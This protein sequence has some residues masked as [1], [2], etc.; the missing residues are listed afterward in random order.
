MIES[1]PHQPKEKTTTGSTSGDVVSLMV[2]C[3]FGAR[4]F[5]ILEV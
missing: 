5:G 3:W 1:Q 2:N 4:W